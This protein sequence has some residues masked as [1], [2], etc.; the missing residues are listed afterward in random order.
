M[1]P[2]LFLHCTEIEGIV[3]GRG[4]SAQTRYIDLQVDAL[5][6]VHEFT[7]IVLECPICFEESNMIKLS[8]SHLLCNKCWYDITLNSCLASGL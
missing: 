4:G 5:G 7:N 6:K 8:C 1:K 2:V 3:A